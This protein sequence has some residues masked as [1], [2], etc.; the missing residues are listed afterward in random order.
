M[1]FII[2]TV[3]KNAASIKDYRNIKKKVPTN[4]FTLLLLGRKYLNFSNLKK[5]ISDNKL[6]F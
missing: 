2:V 6:F 5:I 3:V 4:I 1:F